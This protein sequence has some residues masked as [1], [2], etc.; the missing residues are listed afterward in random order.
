[1]SGCPLVPE[2]KRLVTRKYLEDKGDW[3]INKVSFRQIL[4]FV[5][6]A[7]YSY[8]LTLDELKAEKRDSR[9]TIQQRHTIIKD[10]IIAKDNITAKTTDVSLLLRDPVN[11]GEVIIMASFLMSVA[12][13]VGY[14]LGLTGNRKNYRYSQR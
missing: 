12:L 5:S 11:I 14:S 2:L 13:G 7:L 9:T 4:L 6:L 10:N 1:M 3:D 8:S